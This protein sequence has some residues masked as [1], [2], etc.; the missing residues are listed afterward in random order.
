M[1]SVATKHCVG[2]L[3]ER[4][5]SVSRCGGWPGFVRLQLSGTLWGAWLGSSAIHPNRLAAEGFV[6]CGVVAAEQ[7]VKEAPVPLRPPHDADVLPE[8]QELVVSPSADGLP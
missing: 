6:G 3:G 8:A 7:G 1:W 2:L 5:A 4:R